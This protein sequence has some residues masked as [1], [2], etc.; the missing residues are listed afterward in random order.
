[1]YL[2]TSVITPSLFTATKT[3]NR[4]VY[5]EARDRLG[6]PPLGSSNPLAN[7]TDVLLHNSSDQIMETSIYNIALFRSSRWITPSSE[8]GCL[9]GVMRRQLLDEEL[10]TEEVL[11]VNSLVDGEPCLLFN[12]VRGC[13]RG[14]LKLTR[15]DSESKLLQM[16]T[17]I[18]LSSTIP[19][20]ISDSTK[21]IM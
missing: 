5:D 12:G 6:I 16:S 20:S 8:T 17:S 3:T 11:L 21:S 13:L 4:T 2:D 18:P 1:V 19:S 15:S 9:P 7:S 14:I 10:I